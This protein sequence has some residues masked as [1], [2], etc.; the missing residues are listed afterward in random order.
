M[1]VDIRLLGSDNQWK[2]PGPRIRV[3]RDPGCDVSLSPE[4]FPMVSREHLVILIEKGHVRFNDSGSANGTYVNGVKAVQGRLLNS[5]RVRLGS[6][7]PELEIPY[8]DK[9]VVGVP[10][11]KKAVDA[12][13][14]SPAVSLSSPTL[15]SSSDAATT[16]MLQS[17]EPAPK[18]PVPASTV[19]STPQPPPK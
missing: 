6:D 16:M 4:R 5:D 1:Q 10:Q 2:F 8:S 18:T 12:T 17:D 15:A 9:P 13:V 19:A 14:A 7:G 3:G 11:A